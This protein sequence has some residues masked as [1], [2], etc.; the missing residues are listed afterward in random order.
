MLIALMQWQDN[1]IEFQF[2]IGYG[3]RFVELMLSPDAFEAFRISSK[4]AIL[5]CR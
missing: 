1:F 5:G 4:V 2:A 3:D